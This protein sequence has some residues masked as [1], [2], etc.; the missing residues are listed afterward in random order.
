[1][2]TITIKDLVANANRKH[3][4][5]IMGVGSKAAVTAIVNHADS[6]KDRDAFVTFG[7]S[8]LAALRERLAAYGGQGK[9]DRSAQVKMT[10][11]AIRDLDGFLASFTRVA[12]PQPAPVATTAPAKPVSR[13]T[14]AELIAMVEFL[15]A[16]A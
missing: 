10:S 1:M 3:A 14:K 8:V 2:T 11:I 16:R 5:P 7:Q 12:A 13:M 9:T 4:N 15:A 6:V